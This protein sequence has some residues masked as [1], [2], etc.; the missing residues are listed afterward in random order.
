MLNIRKPKN[1]PT[2]PH[3]YKTHIEKQEM[4]KVKAIMGQKAEKTGY[5]RAGISKETTLN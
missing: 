2:R 4:T 3:L 5:E 1:I